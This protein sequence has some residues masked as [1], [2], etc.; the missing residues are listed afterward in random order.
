MI[1]TYSDPALASAAQDGSSYAVKVCVLFLKGLIFVY[2]EGCREFCL[3]AGVS[4][5]VGM[6]VIS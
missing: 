1:N 6:I 4:N 3:R 2:G 5:I